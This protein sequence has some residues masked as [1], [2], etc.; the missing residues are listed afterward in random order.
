MNLQEFRKAYPQYDDLSDEAVVGNLRKSYPDMPIDEFHAKL[1]YSPG[2]PVAQGVGDLVAGAIRGA[3]SIGATLLAP[4]DWA[5]RKLNQ[6]Q[7]VNVGG[8]DIVGQDRRAGMDEA[9]KTM[10]ANP[11]S[12]LFQTGKIGAEIA[13]TMGAGGLAGQG[14]RAAAPS[15]DALATALSTGGLRGGNLATRVAGGAGAGGLSAGMVDPEQALAGAGW[16]AAIPGGL[17]ALGA[18]A[19]KVTEKAADLGRRALDMGIKV[20]YDRLANSPFLNRAIGSLEYVPGAGRATTMRDMQDQIQSAAAK[21]MGQAGPDMAEGVRAAKKELGSEFDRVIRGTDVVADSQLVADLQAASRKAVDELEPSQAKVVTSQIDQIL[22]KAEGGSIQGQ[23]AYNTKMKL[24]RISARPIVGP[25]AREVRTSLMN[26][27][28]R[29]L[30]PDE[31]AAFAKT[32]QQYGNMKDLEGLVKRG[33]EGDMSMARVGNLPQTTNKDLGEV[34]DIA[35]QFARGRES[36]HGLAQTALATILSS[37]GLAGGG[38]GGLVGAPLA[39][40]ALGRGVNSAMN[41]NM[42]RRK[43]LGLPQQGVLGPTLREA[44]KGLY[45]GAPVGLMELMQGR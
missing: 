36:P 34:A 44:R 2:S 25:Y 24:D 39:A 17:G 32:R 20:P 5:A 15:L 3:G 41:S 6:G 1:G 8:Y 28:G 29:S 27:L 45:L 19:P 14:V 38:L 31:A 35:S 23:T 22:S 42:L 9:L 33:S 4:V 37:A 7:P 11:E 12:G 40:A 30:G 10:G 13:G 16:G 21:T 26:A 18:L 43:A